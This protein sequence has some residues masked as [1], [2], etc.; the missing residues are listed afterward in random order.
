MNNKVQIKRVSGS[1]KYPQLGLPAYAN[2]GDAGVDLRANVF[3]DK[4]LSP[5]ESW[6]C[7]TGIMLAMPTN[8]QAEVRPRSGLALKNRITVLN[9]PGTIDA[10]YRNEV[11]VIL[12]NHS[13]KIFRIQR[14]DR[15]AQLV[16]MPVLQV[17]FEEVEVLPKS[18]R[19]KSGFGDSGVK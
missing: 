10:G 18:E 16:F 14:G 3:E 17:E 8:M 9:T 1:R 15:I 5:G 6:L 4:V 13:K 11:G 12:I 7:P 19:G 2:E